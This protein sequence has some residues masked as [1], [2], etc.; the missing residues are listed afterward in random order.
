MNN[1]NLVLSILLIALIG[2]VSLSF[3]ALAQEKKA[4]V[5]REGRIITFSGDVKI[6]KSGS[7]QM[8]PVKKNMVIQFGDLIKTGAASY[9]EVAFDEKAQTILGIQ[10][11]TEVSFDELSRNPMTGSEVTN[12]TLSMG[13]I[14][15]KVEPL[16][17]SES[18]FKIKTPTAA[19][20]VRG[21]GFEVRVSK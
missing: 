12:L 14:L 3:F 15:T 9:A 11:N 4:V 2:V 8:L 6:L 21:T 10:E 1:K 13:S 5:S 17:T 16:K 7:R 19:V 20:G 18:E